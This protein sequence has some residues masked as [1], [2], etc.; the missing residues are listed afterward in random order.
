MSSKLAV[1][2]SMRA[3]AADASAS[4]RKPIRSTRRR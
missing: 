2:A 1:S 4:S 3:L